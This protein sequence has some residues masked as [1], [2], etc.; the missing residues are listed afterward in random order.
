MAFVMH[1]GRQ[2]VFLYILQS[3]S[4]CKRIV[5][6]NCVFDLDPWDDVLLKGNRA[7][8]LHNVFCCHL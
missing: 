7:V 3:R 8:C 2:H 4:L 1:I 6:F 5:N